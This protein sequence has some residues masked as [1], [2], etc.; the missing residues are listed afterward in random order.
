MKPHA[1]LHSDMQTIYE[2][3]QPLVAQRDSGSRF[4]MR[5]ALHDTEWDGVWSE[6]DRRRPEAPTIS[7]AIALTRT[8]PHKARLALLAAL[9]LLALP[10]PAR[11]LS[12]GGATHGLQREALFS[13][14][15][16]EVTL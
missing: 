14:S 1:N 5:G 11:L 12:G 7:P 6:H 13:F 3:T 4:G 15:P 2:G 10:F 9:A 16:I 8:G